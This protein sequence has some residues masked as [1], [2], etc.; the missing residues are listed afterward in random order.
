MKTISCLL[1]TAIWL[2]GLVLISDLAK[3][4]VL[5]TAAISMVTVGGLIGSLAIALREEHG[6][7]VDQQPA[8]R[9]AA[10]IVPNIVVHVQSQRLAL[11][12]PSKRELTKR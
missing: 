7:P 9:A 4:D 11:P 6:D 5:I 2:L 8:E 10:E 1:W 3:V 12:A